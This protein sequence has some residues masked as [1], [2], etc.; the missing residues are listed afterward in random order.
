MTCWLRVLRTKNNVGNSGILYPLCDFSFSDFFS[1]LQERCYRHQN[2]R[3]SSGDN[4]ISRGP[5]DSLESCLTTTQQNFVQ[6]RWGRPFTIFQT[7]WVTIPCGLGFIK[8]AFAQFYKRGWILACWI[9]PTEVIETVVGEGSDDN[10]SEGKFPE[11]CCVEWSGREERWGFRWRNFGG[12]TVWDEIPLLRDKKFKGLPATGLTFMVSPHSFVVWFIVNHKI[13]DMV[14]AL[15]TSHRWRFALSI[16]RL[17]V[18][19]RP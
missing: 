10:R 8:P 12:D 2:R 13:I 11:G 7:L 4:Q 14:L 18:F 17:H 6:P 1:S 19:T 9:C 16:R 15:R 3:I 5:H